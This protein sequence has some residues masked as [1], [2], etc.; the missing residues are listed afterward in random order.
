MFHYTLLYL[1]LLIT[2]LFLVLFVMRLL[3]FNTAIM[4]LLIFGSLPII[5]S[6]YLHCVSKG[7][8]P[9]LVHCLK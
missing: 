7:N 6:F 3:H 1:Y 5:L 8:I 2:Y 9:F 4:V